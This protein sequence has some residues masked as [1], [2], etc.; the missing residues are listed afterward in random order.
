MDDEALPSAIHNL[1]GLAR[2]ALQT[3]ERRYEIINGAQ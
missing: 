3:Y 2:D 1:T